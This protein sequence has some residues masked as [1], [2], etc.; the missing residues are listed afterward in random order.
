MGTALALFSFGYWGW[1]SETPLLLDATRA[2]EEARGFIAP[3]FVD[4]RALRGA[5]AAGFREKLFEKLAG[6]DNYVWMPKL[7]N[8]RVAEGSDGEAEIIEPQA[9]GDLLDLA[10]ERLRRKQRLIFFC[11]CEWPGTT[12]EPGCHR[13][14]VTNLVLEEARRRKL[15]I[16]IG[17]W[18]GGEPRNVS[19]K[20]TR[21]NYTKLASGG[22]SLK[23]SMSVADAAGLPWGSRVTMANGGDT[24]DFIAG[25]GKA[26]RGELV[27]PRMVAGFDDLDKEWGRLKRRLG[28]GWQTTGDRPASEVARRQR[29]Q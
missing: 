26:S 18:P 8:R 21:K 20:V 24:F 11:A 17:E 15:A 28:L 29:R 23:T 16:G 5:R 1:G 27:T 13:L 22:A 9:A 3:C 4:V 12:K 6:P 25:P 7:G 19:V 2:V 10:V 14:L